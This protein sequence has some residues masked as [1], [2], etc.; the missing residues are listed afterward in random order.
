MKKL[1]FTLFSIIIISSCAGAEEIWDSWQDTNFYG[2]SQAVSDEDFDKAIE[3]KKTKKNFFGFKKKEKNKA[4]PKGE[5]FSQSDET[6]FITESAKEY[7]IIIIP[8]ELIIDEFTIL[9]VGHYQVIGDD[10]DKNDI[11]LKFYQ[12]GQLIASIGAKPT[13]DDFNQQEVNFAFCRYFDD[14]RM[15]IIFGSIDFNA[16]SLVNIR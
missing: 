5:E 3:S 2:K 1:L 9:P 6:T 12:A 8:V 14:K 16:Y 10:S 15:E 11:K 4:I 7:P 13:K